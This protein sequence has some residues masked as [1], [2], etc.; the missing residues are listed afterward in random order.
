MLMM[1]RFGTFL[2]LAEARRLGFTVDAS[3]SFPATTL[4]AS[5]AYATQTDRARG[6]RPNATPF[7]TLVSTLYNNT[8]GDDQVTI[9]ISCVC[10]VLSRLYMRTHCLLWS[11]EI[12]TSPHM[13]S[14]N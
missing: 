12:Q 10:R 7:L 8:L 4:P 13:G 2:P 6:Q 3:P 5:F 14:L 1:R 9:W 11:S